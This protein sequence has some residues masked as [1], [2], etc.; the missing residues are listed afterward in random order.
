MASSLP[1]YRQGWTEDLV[2]VPYNFGSRR[3]EQQ[4]PGMMSLIKP[5]TTMALMGLT[6]ARDSVKS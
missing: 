3:I 1:F 6:S 2:F 5:R 4:T